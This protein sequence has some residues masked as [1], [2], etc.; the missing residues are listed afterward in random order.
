[1]NPRQLQRK[2]ELCTRQTHLKIALIKPGVT[3][4]S[5][6]SRNGTPLAGPLKVKPTAG[7]LRQGRTQSPRGSSEA[8]I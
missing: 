6:R 8:L 1:M 7:V 2:P 4:L 3:A 5:F